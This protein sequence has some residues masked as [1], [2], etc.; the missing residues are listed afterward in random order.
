MDRLN[1]LARVDATSLEAAVRGASQAREADRAI[2]ELQDKVVKGTAEQVD[3]YR[4]SILNSVSRKG[5]QQWKSFATEFGLTPASR[6]KFA[7]GIGG[8]SGPAIVIDPLEA[9]LCG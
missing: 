6:G 5:W 7:L 3:Y 1:L 8:S 9:A 2:E 4:L